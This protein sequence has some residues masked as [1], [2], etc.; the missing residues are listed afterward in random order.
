[1]G[2]AGTVKVLLGALTLSELVKR[3]AYT[4]GGLVFY[5]VEILIG[6]A[7]LCAAVFLFARRQWIARVLPPLAFGFFG[8][9]MCQLF[10]GMLVSQS[11]VPKAIVIYAADLLALLIAAV[12]TL[13]PKV[14]QYVNARNSEDTAP[15]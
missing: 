1:L 13:S 7:A 15:V 10:F 14:T 4:S 5:A 11:F 6:V 8:W 12:A 3:N 2:S 9:E